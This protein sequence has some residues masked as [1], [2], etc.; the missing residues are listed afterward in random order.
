M[1]NAEELS[2]SYFSAGQGIFVFR[3]GVFPGAVNSEKSIPE[4]I[5]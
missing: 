4:A 2:G 5:K 3:K 1:D